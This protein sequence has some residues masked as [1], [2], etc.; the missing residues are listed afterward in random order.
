M[1][2]FFAIGAAAA[3]LAGASLV[4]GVGG[5]NPTRAFAAC[6]VTVVS[7]S[8]ANTTDSCT[9]AATITLNQGALSLQVPTLTAFQVAGA[10]LQLNGQDQIATSTWVASANTNGA[11][12]KIVDA[13]GTGN[14]WHLTMG[15]P[16]FQC[17]TGG[18]C[19]SSDKFPANELTGGAFS[20]YSCSLYALQHCGTLRETGPGTFAGAGTTPIDNTS[21]AGST[22]NPVEEVSAAA[23]TGMGTFDVTLTGLSLHVPADAYATTY[24]TII[25]ATLASNP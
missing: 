3:L 22:N 24:T 14:G 8:P 9:I 15:S 16:Q 17:V 25:T 2:K 13:T 4:S 21:G 11:T 19:Q 6:P 20:T 12:F 1:R 23:N 18:N 7:G 10:T 5:F